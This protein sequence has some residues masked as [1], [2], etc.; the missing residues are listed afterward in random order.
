MLRAP[1]HPFTCTPVPAPPSRRI[2]KGR[3]CT[4][5]QHRDETLHRPAASANT[6]SSS[7]GGSRKTGKWLAAVHPL[8]KFCSYCPHDSPS[9]TRGVKVASPFTACKRNG[10]ITRK[11]TF[12]DIVGNEGRSCKQ[13]RKSVQRLHAECGSVFG[14]STVDASISQQTPTLI[15]VDRGH[16]DCSFCETQKE[17]GSMSRR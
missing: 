10:S 15:K 3:I 13:T 14:C 11:T 7:P 8:T 4:T 9:K 12:G 1:S 5:H 2:G 16:V 6:R 17:F